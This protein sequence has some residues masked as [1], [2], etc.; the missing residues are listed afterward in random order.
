MNKP[1]SKT[2]LE[3]MQYLWR[4][5]R[6]V[7]AREIRD[8]FSHK[9]WSKQTISTYLKRLVN[10]GYLKIRK[11]SVTKYYYSVTM[12]KEQY[13]LLPVND[14]VNS[15]Y[16]GSLSKFICA[17]INPNNIT[18]EELSELE[19]YLINVKNNID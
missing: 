9:E 17:L 18:I 11:Q 7:T 16:K 10:L 15:E 2:E 13:N 14:I 3:I 6:E 4:I 19:F 1:L 12:S 5:N 8:N